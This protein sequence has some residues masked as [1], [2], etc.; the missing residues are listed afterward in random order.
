ME[1]VS[2]AHPPITIAFDEDAYT[3]AEGA[4]AEDVNIYVVATLDPAY[5]RVVPVNDIAVLLQTEPDSAGSPDDFD[6]ISGN[7][8]LDTEDIESGTRQVARHLFA[9]GNRKFAIVDDDALR[10]T[11]SSWRWRWNLRRPSAPDWCATGMPT[12][13]SARALA[14]K[15][16]TR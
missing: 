8:N 6:P 15:F 3:F 12:A 2:L 7:T 5:P 14:A 16:P 4:E 1:I 13:A 11:R 10:R 9:E